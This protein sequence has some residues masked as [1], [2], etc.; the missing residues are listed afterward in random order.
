MPQFVPKPTRV[1]PLILKP[2]NAKKQTARYQYATDI[3]RRRCY[4]HFIYE[5]PGIPTCYSFCAVT[6]V[7]YFIIASSATS[8]TLPTINCYYT[9][10]ALSSV[11]LNYRNSARC[12]YFF[13]TGRFHF[14]LIVFKKL[15]STIKNRTVL[16]HLCNILYYA[17]LHCLSSRR[18]LCLITLFIQALSSYRTQVV[19]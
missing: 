8:Q 11:C 18:K 1:F 10:T 16:L 14:C 6:D 13:T 12:L 2:T 4:R 17:K 15:S 3:P 9:K 7:D 19:S 5:M